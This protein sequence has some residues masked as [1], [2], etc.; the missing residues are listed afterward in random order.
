MCVVCEIFNYTC[1]YYCSACCQYL[2]KYE[3]HLASNSHNMFTASSNDVTSI[4][5]H[6]DADQLSEFSDDS[7][8]EDVNVSFIVCYIEI[9]LLL[10]SS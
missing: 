4:H 9:L 5:V 1:R 6:V 7:Y 8:S 3:R 2:S 10:T